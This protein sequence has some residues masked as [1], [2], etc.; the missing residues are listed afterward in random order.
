MELV[1]GYEY[2]IDHK[3]IISSYLLAGKCT[4]YI[5]D[6][7]LMAVNVKVMVLWDVA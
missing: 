4:K 3:V 5:A 7:V 6:E 1:G 2:E